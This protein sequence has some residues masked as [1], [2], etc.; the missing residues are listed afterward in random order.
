MNFGNGESGGRNA[1]AC[2]AEITV[3]HGRR[4]AG[5]GARGHFIVAVVPSV[6]GADSGPRHDHF[7]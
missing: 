6:T 2:A 7:S 4:S 3:E 1:N 5:P